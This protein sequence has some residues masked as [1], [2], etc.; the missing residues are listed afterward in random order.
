MDA[1]T[2][3]VVIV[4]VFAVIALA[5]F[6]IYRNS[7]HLIIGRGGLRLTGTS[8]P[9]GGATIEDG[10]AEEG[11]ATAEDGF[12]GGAAIRRVTAK[13]DLVARSAPPGGPKDPP[14]TT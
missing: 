1:N 7:T 13:Q 6:L 3:V 10:K 9:R 8:T 5:S 2:T 4:I 12:G 11:S 14:P